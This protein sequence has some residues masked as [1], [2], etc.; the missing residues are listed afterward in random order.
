MEQLTE[1]GRQLVGSGIVLGTGR[2]E[3]TLKQALRTH[4]AMHNAE[5]WLFREALMR[6][7]DECGLQVSGALETAAYEQA[8]AAAGLPAAGVEERVSEL[9]RELGPPWGRDQK[10]AAAVAWM[11]LAQ[12]E[13]APSATLR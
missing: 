5:G 13:Q 3:F 9:G 8:A 12:S 1:S 4:A 2:P 7:A 11:A 6:A 10:L